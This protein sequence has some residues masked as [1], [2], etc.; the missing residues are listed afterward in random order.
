MEKKRLFKTSPEKGSGFTLV[1][2]LIVIALIGVLAAALVA[3]LNPIEQVNKA[4]DSRFKNDAAELL[5]ALER[6][7]AS[8]QAYPWMEEGGAF[9]S[10]SDCTASD[11]VGFQG[12]IEAVGVCDTDCDTNGTLIDSGELKPSFMNKDQFDDDAD[13]IDKLYVRKEALSSG[14]VYVCFIP[15]AGTNQS[16]SLNPNL[17]LWDVCTAGDATGCTAY[18]DPATCDPSGVSDWDDVSDACFICIPE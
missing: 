17:R 11:E 12:E 10:G 4:R 2:L 8:T 5:A 3:T 18:Q 14:A 7:Y 16:T 13:G 9:C 6:Y 1:E 15:K